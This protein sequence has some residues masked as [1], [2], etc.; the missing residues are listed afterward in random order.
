MA[1]MKNSINSKVFYYN[2]F[3]ENS[4]TYF[5]ELCDFYA[6]GFEILSNVTTEKKTEGEN[7]LKVLYIYLTEDKN[8][9]IKLYYYLDTTSTNPLNICMDVIKNGTVYLSSSCAYNSGKYMHFYF[10]VSDY[11]II[12][13]IPN[14]SMNSVTTSISFTDKQLLNYNSSVSS[15]DGTTICYLNGIFVPDDEPTI[16]WNFSHNISTNADYNKY[17]IFSSNHANQEKIQESS[18][19]FAND[20][21]SQKILLIHAFSFDYPINTPHLYRVLGR[22]NDTSTGRISVSG[23]TLYWIGRFGLEFNE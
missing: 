8:M 13:T 17:Q 18:M 2:T 3:Y 10:F 12:F 11:G 5:D 7:N 1:V 14:S 16:F 23:K 9:Y 15:S 6:S 20:L 22:S 21:G 4:A 19:Y